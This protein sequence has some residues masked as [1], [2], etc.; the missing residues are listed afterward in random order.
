MTATESQTIRIGM[1]TTT[2]SRTHRTPDPKITT[3]TE[4]TTQTTMTTTATE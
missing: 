4:S 2:E 3:T 1:T